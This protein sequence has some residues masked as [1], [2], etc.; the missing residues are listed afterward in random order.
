MMSYQISEVYGVELPAWAAPPDL[1]ANH[2]CMVGPRFDE[3][4][5]VLCTPLFRMKGDAFLVDAKRKLKQVPSSEWLV[6]WPWIG[7]WPQKAIG[8]GVAGV[9][10]GEFV[11]GY[12]PP[13]Y[14]AQCV[15]GHVRNEELI[16]T[17]QT[18]IIN[19][20]R[21]HF[22]NRDP[23]IK[24][25]VL[26]FEDFVYQDKKWELKQIEVIADS[27]EQSEYT[28]LLINSR[29]TKVWKGRNWE[30]ELE[31]ENKPELVLGEHNLIMLKRL[32]KVVFYCEEF[33]E[34]G[35][36]IPLVHYLIRDE[37][38]AWDKNWTDTYV[39]RIEEF[40]Y[41]TIQVVHCD[42]DS[43][44]AK[45]EDVIVALDRSADSLKKQ[46]EVNHG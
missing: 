18:E 39:P 41:G 19:L 9:I 29:H 46:K 11:V 45:V 23:F 22:D 43:F 28:A 13:Q 17:D 37:N 12:F 35:Q 44:V 31:G 40:M 15:T 16:W 32:S 5:S 1:E 21:L 34:I 25:P 24:T 14:D 10:N 3:F 30:F 33:N 4:E 42:L 27:F 6:Y 8:F 36:F 20:A 7:F 26:T 2:S 38:R